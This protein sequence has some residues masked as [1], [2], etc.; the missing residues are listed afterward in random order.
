VFAEPEQGAPL[1]RA[2]ARIPVS[3]LP[4]SV[5]VRREEGLGQVGGREEANGVWHWILDCLGVLLT[6][7][8]SRRH[9]D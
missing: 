2:S 6:W 9:C 1:A 5:E 3:G 7:F 8:D 4:L